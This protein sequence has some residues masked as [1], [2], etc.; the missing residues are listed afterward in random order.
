M[1]L[2]GK[3]IWSDQ[4]RINQ[5]SEDSVKKFYQSPHKTQAVHHNIEYEYYLSFAMALCEGEIVEI[6][7][8]WVGDEL[9]DLSNYKFC[10]YN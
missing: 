4:L 3:I 7:R 10:L 6:A 2:P 9:V 5:I 8:V 1:R